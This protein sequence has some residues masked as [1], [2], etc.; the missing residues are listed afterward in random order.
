MHLDTGDPEQI[1]LNSFDVALELK[2]SL[3]QARQAL[4]R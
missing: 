4:Q 3:V 2:R 1:I